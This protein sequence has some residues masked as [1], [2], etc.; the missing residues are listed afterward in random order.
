M[1]QPLQD[2]TIVVTGASSGIGQAIAVAAAA[3]GANVLIHYRKNESGARTTLAACQ[4]FKVESKIIEG[5]IAIAADRDRLIESAFEW[6]KERVSAW[7][8]NAGADVLT[9]KNQLL[10]FEQKLDLLWDVDV[11]STLL[12]SRKVMERFY[13]TTPHDDHLPSMIFVGWDQAHL[14]MEGEP[15]Q[16][17]GTI[18]GAVM[19]MANN[20]AQDARDRVRVNCIAPGWIRTAWGHEASD[21]WQDRAVRES[22]LRRWGTAQDVAAAAVFLCSNQASFIHGQVIPVNGG[23]VQ[24]C[25][26]PS[27]ISYTS[28][29]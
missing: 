11:R 18:K 15:G 4:R 7:I 28:R 29:G 16:L 14:G 23:R 6:S 1:N 27:K 3:A 17:F 21:E 26:V 25:S 10:T 19:A 22:L 5:D 2:H 20:F 12:L 8:N 24:G 13:S 9:G